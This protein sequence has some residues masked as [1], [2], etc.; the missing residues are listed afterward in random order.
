MTQ[1]I[2]SILVE[3]MHAGGSR[4]ESEGAMVGGEVEWV[5]WQKT[6]GQEG[7]GGSDIAL[8]DVAKK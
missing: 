7:P 5:T 4:G 1:A 3:L 6:A 8:S 2:A